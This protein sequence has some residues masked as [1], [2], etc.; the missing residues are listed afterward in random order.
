LC[1]QLVRADYGTDAAIG[2]ARYMVVA[3]HRDGGQAQL[4]ERP[5]PPP[6]RA[7]RPPA[8]GRLNTWPSR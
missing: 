4:L 1:V 7:W 8:T 2:I 6:A 5:V 3:P